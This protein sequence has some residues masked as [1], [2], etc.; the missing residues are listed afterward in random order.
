MAFLE[1][2]RLID[3]EIAKHKVVTNDHDKTCLGSLI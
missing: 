1:M 3:D 2:H